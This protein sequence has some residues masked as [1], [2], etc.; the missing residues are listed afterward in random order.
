ML[1]CS[2]NIN[3]SG[4]PVCLCVSVCIFM[5]LAK[6]FSLLVKEVQQ[7]LGLKLTLKRQIKVF[8]FECVKV[9]DS[10]KESCIYWNC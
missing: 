2:G 6:S 1:V 4:L 5:P 3:L 10:G 8:M 7:F 9:E